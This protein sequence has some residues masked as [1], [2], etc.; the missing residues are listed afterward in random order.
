[1]PPPFPSRSPRRTV[2]AVALAAWLAVSGCAAID[3]AQ[4]HLQHALQP[5]P[6]P[7]PITVEQASTLDDAEVRRRIA[8]LS[9]RLDRSRRHATI[10]QVGWLAVNTG[11]L[12]AGALQATADE[13]DDRAFGIIG[14]TKAALGTAYLLIDPMPGRTGA[15]PIRAMS[16]ATAT[17][18]TEQLVA[19]EALVYASAARSAQRTAWAMHAGNIALNLIGGAI[20]LGRDAPELAALSFGVDA[21]VG[22]VQILSQPW[23]PRR[24]WTE[25]Q[26]TLVAPGTR[27]AARAP[28][29]RLAPSAGGVAFVWEY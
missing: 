27:D 19:A 29:W 24:D 3:R 13:A 6:G 12:A 7:P 18:R 4:S 14:A 22:T 16:A 25:Y 2:G 28:R 20:L 21:N 10:W 17:D 9:E 26:E 5:A 1:M 11:G 15:D 23:H 8:F